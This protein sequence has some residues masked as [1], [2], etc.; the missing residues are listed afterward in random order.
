M[1]KN[2]NWTPISLMFRNKE[3]TCVNQE[4]YEGHDKK[5]HTHIAAHYV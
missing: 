2:I 1:I 3:K 4:Q 5:T